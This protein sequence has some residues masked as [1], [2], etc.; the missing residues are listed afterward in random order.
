MNKAKL[1]ELLEDG[2]YFNRKESKFY[3]PSF[4][5]GF[6]KLTNHNISWQ[7]VEREHGLFG[8]KRLSDVDGVYSL[9]NV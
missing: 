6:R 8:T 3:H 4:R 9:I 5:Q 2:A 1:I 7:A